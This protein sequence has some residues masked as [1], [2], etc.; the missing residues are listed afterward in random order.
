[1]RA[2]GFDVQHERMGGDGIA[3]WQ[4]APSDIDGRKPPW[5]CPPRPAG[6]LTLLCVTRDPFA[7]IPSVMYTDWNGVSVNWRSRFS[8]APHIHAKGF[9]HAEK[10]ALGV[11]E[12]YKVIA[13]QNPIAVIKVEDAEAEL[14]AYFGREPALS[15][16]RCNQRSHPKVGPQELLGQLRR[17]VR[18]LLR[19]HCLAYGYPWPEE[20]A[21]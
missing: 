20:A 12:W 11:I 1:M 2:F 16:A 6:D 8:C 19:E 5:D 3:A 4:L 10:A 21:A 7:C 9:T 14:S 15:P 13:R 17:H 18:E